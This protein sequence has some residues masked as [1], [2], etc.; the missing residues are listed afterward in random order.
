MIVKQARSSNPQVVQKAIR[1]LGICLLISIFIYV[2]LQ[3]TEG[4]SVSVKDD[5]L[6]LSYSSADSFDISYKD[7]L[8]VEET[9]NLDLGKYISGIDTKNYQFGVWENDE[10]GEY[11]LCVY[12]QVGQYIVMKTSKDVY[13]LNFESIDATDSFYKSFTVLLNQAEATP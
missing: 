13:V 3:K 6:S 7:I 5:D 12:A 4:I 1:M 9:Q 10:F 2:M 8:S 11:K